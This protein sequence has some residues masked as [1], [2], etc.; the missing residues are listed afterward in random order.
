MLHCSTVWRILLLQV[1]ILR[2]GLCFNHW[3][4]TEDG[5]IE[6]QVRVGFGGVSV[7]IGP[8]YWPY[9]WMDPFQDAF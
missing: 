5:K 1:L 8:V 4:V 9:G 7:V 6:H 3:V 2:A